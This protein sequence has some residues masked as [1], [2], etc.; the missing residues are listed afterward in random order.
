M[1]LE[2]VESECRP[3]FCRGC[4]QEGSCEIRRGFV[5]RWRPP[6]IEASTYGF[7]FCPGRSLHA[8][9]LS[10]FIRNKICPQIHSELLPTEEI[11]LENQS[12]FVNGN[13]GCNDEV[14][15]EHAD[16]EIYSTKEGL[17]ALLIASATLERLGTL[18]EEV[19]LDKV[20]LKGH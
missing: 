19:T 11:T 14:G 16:E 18:N 5:S 3:I 15:E 6:E 4:L 12:D 13:P 20:L 10:N 2:P 7:G 1:D 9:F 17:R 8:D